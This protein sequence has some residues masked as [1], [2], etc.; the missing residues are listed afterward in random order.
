MKDIKY[1]DYT[2]DICDAIKNIRSVEKLMNY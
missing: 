2:L 1:S